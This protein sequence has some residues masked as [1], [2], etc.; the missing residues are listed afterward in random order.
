MVDARRVSVDSQIEQVRN[1]ISARLRYQ[2]RVDGSGLTAKL[3]SSWQ[4]HELGAM[5]GAEHAS[6]LANGESMD[7]VAGSNVEVALGYGLLM[8]REQALLEPQIKWREY[9]QNSRELRVGALLRSQ[10]RIR[11]LSSV[12][13]DLIQMRGSS[14][15]SPLGVE[16]RLVLPL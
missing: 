5:F 12:N 2:A 7:A 15:G 4:D 14:T 6:L 9:G 8:N 16:L 11:Q 1:S 13:F 10:H 3:S